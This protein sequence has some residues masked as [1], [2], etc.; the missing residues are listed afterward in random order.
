MI[1][2]MIMMVTMTMMITVTMMILDHA[3]ADDIGSHPAAPVNRGRRLAYRP[4]PPRL[5]RRAAT[6][7][8][9]GSVFIRDCKDCTIAVACQQFRAR[10]CVGCTFFL[11]STTQPVIESCGDLRFACYTLDYFR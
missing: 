2:V 4:L 3:G 5:S 10:D 1:M 9:P 6:K 11:F 8:L 7:P